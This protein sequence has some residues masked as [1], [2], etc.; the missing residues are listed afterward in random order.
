M[1]S[2]LSILTIT[3]NWSNTNRLRMVVIIGKEHTWEFIVVP[4]RIRMCGSKTCRHSFHSLQFT[5]RLL[6]LDCSCTHETYSKVKHWYLKPETRKPDRW[7]EMKILVLRD[8]KAAAAVKEYQT[9]RRVPWAAQN[10]EE[11]KIVFSRKILQTILYFA[12]EFT[13]G[14]E[15]I[16]IVNQ[17]I[18]KFCENRDCIPFVR[19]NFDQ[20][21]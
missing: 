19:M 7:S 3:Q 5:T 6:T 17:P 16:T 11:S 14:N 12:V 21:R 2:F 20:Y 4:F 9:G 18:L 13:K 8:Q 1:F 15:P 10:R